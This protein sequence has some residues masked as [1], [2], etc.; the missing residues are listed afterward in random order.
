VSG[1]PSPPAIRALLRRLSARGRV[2]LDLRPLDV[3]C[4]AYL[5]RVETGLATRPDVAEVVDQLDRTSTPRA[6][7]DEPS[8]D[9][10]V[11][12]IEQFLRDQD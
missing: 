10:L 3:Q 8:S 11:S 6:P 12:E 2:E 5:T 9:E 7:D 4:D 1:S